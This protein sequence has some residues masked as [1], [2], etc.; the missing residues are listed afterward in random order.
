[1]LAEIGVRGPAG[2]I[3]GLPAIA[4][5]H[6]IDLPLSRAAIAPARPIGANR[7]DAVT[8]ATEPIEVLLLVRPVGRIVR[9][10]DITATLSGQGLQVANKPSARC[11]VQTLNSGTHMRVNHGIA[12]TAAIAAQYFDFTHS[13]SDGALID[14]SRNATRRNDG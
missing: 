7:W 13:L 9:S 12:R 6:R 1:M 10:R 2:A 8:G 11:W 4:T 3:S 5:S 14:L